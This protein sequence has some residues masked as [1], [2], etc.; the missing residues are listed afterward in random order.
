MNTVSS[1]RPREGWLDV[2]KGIGIV[3]VVAGHCYSGINPSSQCPVESDVARYLYW[4]HMPLFFVISG[5]LFTPVR[6]WPECRGWALRRGRQLL[7]PYC[8][9]VLLITIVRYASMWASG[10]LDP[11]WVAKDLA[12]VIAG[13]RFAADA[14]NTIW[15]ITCL[16]AT[17]LG[18]ALIS[19]RFRTT[20][21]QLAVIGAAYLLGH[22]EAWIGRPSQLPV[23]WNVDVALVAISYYAFGFHLRRLWAK[24][25]RR[26]VGFLA[27]GT[28]LA[29][30]L[31][32]GDA[33]NLYRYSL[34]LKSLDYHNLVLDLVVPLSFSL[35]VFAVSKAFLSV[36]LAGPVALIGSVSM[37]IMYLHMQANLMV[38]QFSDYGLVPYIIIGVLIPAVVAW[39]VFDRFSLT[40]ALFLGLIS[41]RQPLTNSAN[42][43]RSAAS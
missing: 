30:V 37:P 6:D 33:L 21:V 19:L 24:D 39:V 40:R 35:A 28:F 3:A 31:L 23:P 26:M 43:A 32:A 11:A 7:I 38:R 2:A 29:A 1:G 36:R 18:F 17:Q 27:G 34:A 15:F 5:Y 42:T 12:R 41:N 25:C 9:L 13:G 14:Y 8:S 4:F 22:L 10:G 20:R 16:Y